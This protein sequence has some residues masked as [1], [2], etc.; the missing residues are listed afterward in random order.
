MTAQGGAPDLDGMVACDVLCPTPAPYVDG[1][2]GP[3]E[4]CV[5]RVHSQGMAPGIETV[6]GWWLV[7]TDEGDTWVSDA[8]FAAGPFGTWRSR[9]PDT[10]FAPPLTPIPC[11]AIEDVLA[12]GWKH[13]DP[14]NA[15]ISS[16]GAVLV[17]DACPCGPGCNLNCVTPSPTPTITPTPSSTPTPGPTPTVC[18]QCVAPGTTTC[19]PC[20]GAGTPVCPSPPPPP[21]VVPCASCTP[22]PTPATGTATPATA[23]PV[24]TG[25]PVAAACGL[26]S[27][28]SF[29][30][31]RQWYPLYVGQMPGQR[32]VNW[33]EH[34]GM[35]KDL[36]FA[37][38]SLWDIPAVPG[39]GF[40]A[41]HGNECVDYF[42]LWNCAE[43]ACRMART[44]ASFVAELLSI[45]SDGEFLDRWAI[46]I[47]KNW[48]EVYFDPSEL[49]GCACEDNA[50]RE[51]FAG[52]PE[53]LTTARVPYRF[54]MSRTPGEKTTSPVVCAVRFRHALNPD[55]S[56]NLGVCNIVDSGAHLAF[57]RTQI[58]SYSDASGSGNS[59]RCDRFLALNEYFTTDCYYVDEMCK[60]AK[61]GYCN[62]PRCGRQGRALRVSPTEQPPLPPG[63]HTC[64]GG[65]CEWCYHNVETYAAGR[66]TQ[67][68]TG[69]IAFLTMVS[70]GN[71][72]YDTCVRYYIEDFE[73]AT[74]EEEP[75]PQQRFVC[76]PTPEFWQ[77][78][79]PDQPLCNDCPTCGVGAPAP[80]NTL[81]PESCC[82][83]ATRPAPNASTTP[84][85]SCPQLA[86][87]P[88][89]ADC[90]GTVVPTLVPTPPVGPTW[91][92]VCG[93]A[94][95]TPTPFPSGAPTPTLD[96]VLTPTPNWTPGPTT[97]LCCTTARRAQFQHT[98]RPST[99][100]DCDILDDIIDNAEAPFPVTAFCGT[101]A[102]RYAAIVQIDLCCVEGDCSGELVG[103]PSPL[104][105]PLGVL[106]AFNGN[107]D[108][109]STVSICHAT[110][111]RRWVVRLGCEFD[112]DNLPKRWQLEVNEDTVRPWRLT[113]TYV[114]CY[115]GN[116]AL[117]ATPTATAAASPTP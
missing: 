21:T 13:V 76:A 115:A 2:R 97:E 38:V 74:S 114:C 86:P 29:V 9:G 10:V 106:R 28:P 5:V 98:D 46:G 49:G 33:F 95:P 51:Y 103:C 36:A 67:P 65:G 11:D 84:C 111:Q 57:V 60:S 43:P 100:E 69:N 31:W 93:A 30:D 47:P 25:T 101:G 41:Q 110:D 91:Q 17:E 68:H 39:G 50:L 6:D 48:M 71:C 55:G 59:A 56:M 27:G 53:K 89:Q 20:Q 37:G 63:G 24:G 108:V 8:R 70:R 104:T 14:A 105:P 87:L 75:R 45:S 4:L 90:C 81:T 85:T 23:T 102:D 82:D 79:C 83:D 62:D 66:V 61:E 15:D 73:P 19:E 40:P 7:R 80:Q 112:S 113:V 64:P 117:T 12:F 52:H 88:T 94:T 92:A 107:N 42:W 3:R 77:T 26:G 72:P 1:T 54:R 96:P 58:V 109:I 44:L 32:A 34:A 99:A 18:C 116:C 35:C 22:P 16:V 78:P